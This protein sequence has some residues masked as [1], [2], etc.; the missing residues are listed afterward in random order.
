NS[1]PVIGLI[2][3]K[4]GTLFIKRGA[5]GA[6]EQS[7]NEITQALKNG[8]HVIIFPEG[9]TTDGTSVKKFHSRLFQAAIDAE[10]SVQPIAILYPHPDGVHPNAPFIGDTQFLQSTLDMISETRMDVELHFLSPV[11]AKQYNRD[12]LASITREQILTIINK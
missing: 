2:A 1:W 8:G 12:E 9:T 3:K 5:R 10:V 7:L 4:A 6:A 11:K